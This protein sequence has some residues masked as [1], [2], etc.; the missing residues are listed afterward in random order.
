M[1]WIDAKYGDQTVRGGQRLG[2]KADMDSR[3]ILYTPSMRVYLISD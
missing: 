1:L 2:G 3:Y